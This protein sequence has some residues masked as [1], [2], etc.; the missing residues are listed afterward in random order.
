MAYAAARLTQT[1]VLCVSPD[2]DEG[3]IWQSGRGPAV[4]AA[5][6]LYFETGNGTWNGKRDWGTS[7]IK[8]GLHDN[9]FSIDDYFTP[10]DYAALNARDADLGSTGPMLIPGTNLLV[11]GSKKGI[12]YL[13]DTRKLGHLT[14]DDSGALQ[15]FENNGGRMLAGPAFWD[16]PAGPTVYLWCEA[17]VLKAY[18][19]ANERFVTTPVAKG[20]VGSRGSPGGAL[21]V[22]ANGKQAGTGIVWATLTINRSADHGN[23]AGVLRAFDAESLV[24]LW[25]S[26][27]QPKRDRLGTLVKF[28]P[29][30]VMN[31]RVYIPNY[32]N[33]VQVYGLMK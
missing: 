29:P 27:I 13:F 25:N 12:V 9:T 31:G 17:D 33:A 23:A 22:S 19:L 2:G 28:N 10:H 18:R 15:A 26:E 8:L 6:S 11:A 7:L 21:T 14:P 20:A 5:G 32:D 24:E 4:D 16:A 3:G 30:T 1:A